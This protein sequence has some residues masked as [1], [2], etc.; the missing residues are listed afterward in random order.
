MIAMVATMVIAGAVFGL[1]TAGNSAFRR[2]PGLSD[3]QQNIRMAMDVV[4]RDI[5]RTGQGVPIFAQVFANGRDGVGPMGSGGQASDEIEMIATSECGTKRVC[6]IAGLVYNVQT[7]FEACYGFP[8]PVVLIDTVHHD[9]GVFWAPEGHADSSCGTPGAQNGMI[10]LPPG[11]SDLNYPGGPSFEPDFILVGE[12][13]RYRIAVDTDGVPNLERSRTGGV[14][15]GEATW[16][17]IARGIEDLQVEYLNGTGWNDEPGAVSCGAACAS[18]GQA[19]YDTIV[20]RVRVRLSA[21]ALVTNLEGQTMAPGG[22]DAV[23]GELI[24]EF[25]PK[26]AQGALGIWNGE[27]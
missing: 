14:D 13:A 18:P 1:M 4:A 24:S 25:A 20:Q 26:A 8:T 5:Y 2:E 7:T 9:L 16:Q 3:R 17:I 12:I 21:R 6:K 11:Q 22:P 15:V 27:M 23:R 19:E 10:N